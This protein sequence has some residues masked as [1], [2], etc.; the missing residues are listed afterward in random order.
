MSWF[1]L[2][3]KKDLV[4]GLMIEEKIHILRL[5]GTELV[6]NRDHNLI[7]IPGYFYELEINNKSSRVGCYLESNV[8]LVRPKDLDGINSFL[9]IFDVKAKKTYE[10]HTFIGDLT[11]CQPNTIGL[12][13]IPN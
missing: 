10:S 3:N 2:S 8:T 13:Q 7:N 1:G 11:P 5:Q 9:I 4:K 6:Y 12:L